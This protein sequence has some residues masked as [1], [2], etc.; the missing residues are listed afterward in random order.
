MLIIVVASVVTTLVLGAGLVAFLIRRRNMQLWLPNYVFPSETAPV[1]DPDLPIDLYIAV[2]DHWEPRCYG[3]TDALAMQ[4][5]RRW[6]K[7]YPELFRQFK[8]S[9]GRSPI[10]TCFF[11]Q[12]EYRPE[13]LDELKK[14]CDAGLADVDVHL[15]HRDDTADGLREKL[16]GF[17]ET[18]EH[19][20]GLLRKD[21]ETGQ[22]VYGFIH[23]NWALCNSRRDGMWCGVDQELTVLLETGCYADFTL[24]SA[25]SDTQTGTINSIYYAQDIPGQCKSHDRG[26]RAKVGATA[27]EHHL[28]MIQGPLCL[29]W[30]HRKCGMIPRIENA[31]VTIGRPASIDRLKLWMETGVHVAGAPNSLFI[32]L[33]THG[34]KDGNIDTWLGPDM[35]RFH[36]DLALFAQENPR[37]RYHYVSAWEMAQIVHRL[38]QGEPALPQMDRPPQ[39]RCSARHAGCR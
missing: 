13:Y 38:E 39:G 16:I 26:I 34:C 5:V 18:L 23:G 29:D 35:Q 11:P 19:R 15:H 25:P 8:D 22:T 32:K 2:C 10:H 7:E 31:D 28:L 30:Q 37:V 33:H 17:R 14:L 6:T 3:A 24:P 1:R 9:S 27:P 21:P 36:R 20:H 12:D 4:R